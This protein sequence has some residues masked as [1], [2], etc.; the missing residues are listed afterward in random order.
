MMLQV[1]SLILLTNLET[2]NRVKSTN[3]QTAALL[4]LGIFGAGI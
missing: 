2:E 3:E 1:Y 4:L